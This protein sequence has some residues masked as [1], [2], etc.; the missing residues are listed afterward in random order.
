MFTLCGDAHAAVDEWPNQGHRRG[1][2]VLEGVARPLV[3]PAVVQR[4]DRRRPPCRVAG[5][6]QQGKLQILLAQYDDL[7]LAGLIARRHA[8]HHTSW[9]R[10]ESPLEGANGRHDAALRKVRRQAR[11]TIGVVGDALQSGDNMRRH[12]VAVVQRLDGREHGA[13]D[14]LGVEPHHR[15]RPLRS[16]AASEKTDPVVA[17]RL[18][19]RVDVRC[20]RFDRVSRE[21]LVRM[22]SHRPDRQRTHGARLR[23]HRRR[24]VQGRCIGHLD[25][26]FSPGRVAALPHD[27]QIAHRAKAQPGAQAGLG[28]VAAIGEGAQH[29]EAGAAGQ[30]EHGRRAGWMK[31]LDAGKTD[32]YRSAVGLASV[33]GQVERAH[34][35]VECFAIGQGDGALLR[36]DALRHGL[37]AQ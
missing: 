7:P 20:E 30:P 26:L 21:I 18:S 25:Q 28:R 3:V 16:E 1:P 37:R 14:D 27:D 15:E 5:P 22:M 8:H 4:Q 29:V 12:V 17:Q 11:I 32:R 33:L 2:A 34:L 31:R 9:P 36:D 35:V 23:L 19:Q 24:P 13:G 10:G 6:R